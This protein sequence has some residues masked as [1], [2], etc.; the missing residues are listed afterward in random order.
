MPEETDLE[1]LI[2]DLE[3]IDLERI[4]SDMARYT[5]F[6]EKL[7]NVLG[8][9]EIYRKACGLGQWTWNSKDG[10][11]ID[12]EWLKRLGYETESIENMHGF[13]ESLIHPDDL[14]ALKKKLR[15][16]PNGNTHT[17]GHELRL[18]SSDGDWHWVVM[19]GAETRRDSN[20]P[21][22][23][24]G[25]IR[26]IDLE[27]GIHEWND[28]LR[29]VLKYMI[30]T[31]TGLDG[32]NDPENPIL[33]MVPAE[34]EDD[35]FLFL[36][37]M[38]GRAF[39]REQLR[40][41]YVMDAS[42]RYLFVSSEMAASLG[43]HVSEMINR[44]D[45]EIFGSKEN[46][47]TYMSELENRDWTGRKQIRL[48]NGKPAMFI[49]AVKRFTFAMED[50]EG[51]VKI[52]KDLVL[53]FP[54]LIEGEKTDFD[55]EQSSRIL[56]ISPAMREVI[57]SAEIAA[58][59]DST[60]LLTGESGAG[61]DYM[62]KYIHEHSHRATGPFFVIDCGR[63]SAE[64]AESELFGHEP[65]AYTG[66]TKLKK[67]LIEM[68]EGGTL[69]LNEI[70]ELELKIQVKLLDWLETKEFTRVGGTRKISVNTRLLAATNRDL[71]TDV[72]DGRFRFD[73]FYRLNI[74]RIQIPPLRE[75]KEDI[76]FLANIILE[77]FKS[78]GR[79]S[80]ITF[81]SKSVLKM[82]RHHWPG[83]LRELRN[84]I[85]RVIER[86]VVLG[87][88]NQMFSDIPQTKDAFLEAPSHNISS[89]M[90]GWKWETGFPIDESY[91]EIIDNL[92]RAL[93]SEALERCGRKKTKAARMLGMT[94]D[95][96]N[97]Q[98]KTL[99]STVPK[100]HTT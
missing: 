8:W 68:A 39:G 94:R 95:A 51:R 63:L 55:A 73:L 45:S 100:R 25:L 35:F 77:K 15:L 26:N 78:E 37:I 11:A 33:D 10:L 2:S 44:S 97:R 36:A 28:H 49:D 38:L 84:R 14:I 91:N 74:I 93:I 57:E 69:L 86:V 41:F 65:G 1:T 98:L 64:L 88:E 22:E 67:G 21:T 30:S 50:P 6:F 40:A 83:N 76:P 75:R 53:G 47:D 7:P 20:T 62:A 80:N 43:I 5:E 29:S 12:S 17:F 61:K 99:H 9:Y 85:E 4:A 81:D 72:Q 34:N 31:G 13:P 32:L 82:K 3:A 66:A 54:H 24:A 60:I 96:L 59:T 89:G 16:L 27:K 79:G 90:T 46:P 56:P 52:S 48:V 42:L 92:K 23:V 71:E 58:K 19:G 18:K 87:R 70:G